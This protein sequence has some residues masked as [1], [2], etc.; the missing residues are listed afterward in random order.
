MSQRQ[1]PFIHA[2]ALV[3]MSLI[4]GSSQPRAEQASLSA[5][6]GTWIL[7]YVS[8]IDDWARYL[9]IEETLF[10]LCPTMDCNES[11]VGAEIESYRGLVILS[12]SGVGGTDLRLVLGGYASETDGALFGTR[13]HYSNGAIISGFP[14]VFTKLH[15]SRNVQPPFSSELIPGSVQL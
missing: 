7:E 2:F 8:E 5:F 4:F 9:V 12:K 10:S 15:P 6:F 13:F 3:L 11:I 1:R 14:M